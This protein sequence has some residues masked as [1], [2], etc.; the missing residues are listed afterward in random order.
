MGLDLRIPL[1]LMFLSIGAIML[2]YGFVT[3]HDP[4]YAR[5]LGSNVNIGWGGIMLLFG[6]AMFLLGRRSRQ[7]DLQSSAASTHVPQRNTH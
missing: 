4:M 2:V 1:G 3:M 7:R 6:L 5:S